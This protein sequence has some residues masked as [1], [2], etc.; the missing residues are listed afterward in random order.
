MTGEDGRKSQT[1]AAILDFLPQRRGAGFISGY[2]EEI[3]KRK[4]KRGDSARVSGRISRPDERRRNRSSYY[5]LDILIKFNRSKELLHRGF[6]V[7]FLQR[8]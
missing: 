1:V 5:L 3:K 4:K 6:V 2:R 8:T 7:G